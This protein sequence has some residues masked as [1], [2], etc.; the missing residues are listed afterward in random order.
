MTGINEHFVY[1][2]I[3]ASFAIYSDLYINEKFIGLKKIHKVKANLYLS[4][5]VL[6][7]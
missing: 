6:P 1:K 3:R 7:L 2:P 4:F 5:L